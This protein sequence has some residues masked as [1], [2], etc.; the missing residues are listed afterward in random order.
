MF[1]LKI[2]LIFLGEIVAQLILLLA[3]DK[4]KSNLNTSTVEDFLK[5]LVGENQYNAKI[6][7]LVN[8][9]LKK[10]V[11]C[12]NHFIRK[13]DDLSLAD[14]IYYFIGRAAAVQCKNNNPNI[15][16]FIP[17]VLENGEITYIAIQVKNRVD[18][19]SKIY[20]EKMRLEEKLFNDDKVQENKLIYLAL[21]MNFG[22][23]PKLK[24]E[25]ITSYPVIYKER[26]S[27]GCGFTYRKVHHFKLNGL[28]SS[29]YTCLDSNVVYSLEKLINSCRIMNV[30]DYEI[31]AF[32]KV[33][34]GS[35]GYSAD[36]SEK[37]SKILD[38]IKSLKHN[39]IFK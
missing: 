13:F 10:G 20:L 27:D 25:Y 31:E 16:L 26:A 1:Y 11:I 21:L 38:F 17:V 6:R 15:D 3:F 8:E 35:I 7:A 32:S 12:F 23:T 2:Y 28:S 36:S 24:K 37:N 34:V 30:N 29:L 18:N 39:I 14:T 22:H 5:S 33:T 19:V 4:S 9:D